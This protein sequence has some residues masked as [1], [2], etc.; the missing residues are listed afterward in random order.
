MLREAHLSV[1]GTIVRTPVCI[2][3]AI[4]TIPTHDVRCDINY[5]VAGSIA[6]YIF[7]FSRKLI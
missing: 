3:V 7:D 4:D 5:L 1:I 2:T 6:Y